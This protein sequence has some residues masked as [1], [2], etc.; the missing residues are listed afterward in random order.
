MNIWLDLFF[1]I[2]VLLI[3]GLPLACLWPASGLP[4]APSLI[5]D[6][7]LTRRGN[8]EEKSPDDLFVKRGKFF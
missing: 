6:T 2:R 3:S 1:I 5:Y 4:L 8:K 7:T